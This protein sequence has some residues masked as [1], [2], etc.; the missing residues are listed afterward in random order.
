MT[1]AA[2]T[3]KLIVKSSACPHL[4][5]M[6]DAFFRS[7]GAAGLLMVSACGPLPAYYKPGA[8]VSRLEAD[9]LSCETRALKDAPVATEIR[10]RPAVFYPGHRY[11]SGGQCYY[12]PGYWA[13]GGTYTVDTNRQF[14][15]RLAKAC[16][17]DK[18][19]Q[20]I[21]LKRCTGAST[22][23]ETVGQTL[24]GPLDET[25]CAIRNRDGTVSIRTKG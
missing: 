22:A 13:D 19:Y 16:M 2:F 23:G 4:P 15:Q 18:G 8:E 12:R 6:I 9:T 14:R 20:Q 7:L 10:Q 21:E 24:L 1:E 11:C 5:H 3:V 17:A 25:S